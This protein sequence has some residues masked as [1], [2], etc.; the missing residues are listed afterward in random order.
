M[1]NKKRQQEPTGFNGSFLTVD[2]RISKQHSWPYFGSN[3]PPRALSR[4]CRYLHHMCDPPSLLEPN[5]ART[6]G[7]FCLEKFGPH[8]KWWFS[9]GI[10]LISG[11]SRLVKY[12]NLARYIYIYT[13]PETNIAPEN[14]WLE[15]EISFWG[16][17][18]SGAMLVLGRAPR[19]FDCWTVLHFVWLVGLVLFWYV[20][21]VGLLVC[22]L[23]L[24]VVCCCCCCCCSCCSCSCSCSCSSSFAVVRGGLM[25]LFEEGRWRK[26]ESFIHWVE[27]GWSICSWR[28][29]ES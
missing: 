3:P 23:L 27:I 20:R 25:L 9:K 21:F 5:G 16:G 6:F 7:G 18:F 29:Q 10:P 15:D 12:Y 4:I 11:K 22:C 1:K 28:V 26:C 2:P 17:P 14:E 19:V 13:P 24:L 8:L